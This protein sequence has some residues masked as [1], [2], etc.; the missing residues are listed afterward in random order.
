MDRHNFTLAGEHLSRV[1]ERLHEGG[2]PRSE[3]MVNAIFVRARDL[4]DCA[5]S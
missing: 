4:S 1:S 2:R 5:E 3:L